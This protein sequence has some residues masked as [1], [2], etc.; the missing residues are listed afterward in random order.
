MYCL[1][2]TDIVKEIDNDYNFEKDNNDCLQS[3]IF[4]DRVKQQI[5]SLLTLNEPDELLQDII[6]NG[7][8]SLIPK[9]C[10]V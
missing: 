10:K 9:G 8:R 3:N 7:F 4:F 5:N 1:T 2:N 6:P